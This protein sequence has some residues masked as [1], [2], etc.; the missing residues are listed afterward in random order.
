MCIA[1][2]VTIGYFAHF[3][4]S[5]W[6]AVTVAWISKPGAGDTT[7]RVIARVAGTMLGIVVVIVLAW[8][9]PLYPWDTVPLIGLAV[10]V[11]VGFL[12]PN[13]AIAMV[14]F[15]TFILLVF[16]LSGDPVEATS[17]DRLVATLIGG[18]IVVPMSLLWPLYISQLLVLRFTAKKKRVALKLHMLLFALFGLVCMTIRVADPSAV[19]GRL[20]QGFNNEMVAQTTSAVL[21]AAASWIVASTRS[22]YLQINQPMPRFVAPALY[23]SV[24]VYHLCQTITVLVQTLIRDQVPS[25]Y[26]PMAVMRLTVLLDATQNCELLFLVTCCWYLCLQLRKKIASFLQQSTR[27]GERHQRQVRGPYEV[28]DASHQR[29]PTQHA[30]T[31]VRPQRQD[32]MANQQP[33]TLQRNATLGLISPSRAPPPK[34]L[35]TFLT[36]QNKSALLLRVS[37]IGGSVGGGGGGGGGGAKVHPLG[38]LAPTS[39]TLSPVSPGL[40]QA[41]GAGSSSSSATPVGT[42]APAGL[43]PSLPG[44][45]T[46]SIGGGGGGSGGGGVSGGGGGPG[47]VHSPTLLASPTFTAGP[48]S[49]NHMV[50]DRAQLF[51]AALRKITSISL[52][53]TILV[54]VA[55]Y[56]TVSDFQLFAQG[57][58]E[59][60]DIYGKDPLVYSLL[61]SL[62]MTLL[63]TALFVIVWYVFPLPCQTCSAPQCRFRSHSMCSH[64]VS[65]EFEFVHVCG[66]LSLLGTFGRPHRC[67]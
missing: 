33:L 27:V 51:D 13:Y 19:Y 7:I 43:P 58:V 42:A 24:V 14:G 30:F 11:V 35:A 12:V 16:S 54:L 50:V 38:S 10:V 60:K 3:P 25:H 45:G 26:S 41:A 15:T 4:H 55:I 36:Q 28:A 52:A 67:G 46:G 18:A 53:S 47:L 29:A 61:G 57:E 6:I 2:A 9:I 40:P 56:N 65:F 34:S 23:V 5:Y 49:S 48:V 63:A 59:K 21:Y 31:F 64:S 20:S 17:L 37:S 32:S 66:L 22:L 39:P 1:A 62:A 8:A 44:T